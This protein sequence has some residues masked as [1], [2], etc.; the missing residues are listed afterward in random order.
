M[1]EGV[2]SVSDSV[3]LLVID[4][5]SPDK[6]A[7]I[8]RARQV[9]EPRIPRSVTNTDEPVDA[10]FQQCPASFDPRGVAPGD[11]T[12]DTRNRSRKNGVSPDS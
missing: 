8:V 3:E 1:L 6:T 4:D 10:L 9:D 2:L 7:D 11:S 12:V 5:P